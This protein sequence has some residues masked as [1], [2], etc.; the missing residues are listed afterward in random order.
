VA[1]PFARTLTDDYLP[2]S[3]T[4]NDYPD[5]IPAG[6]SVE[7]IAVGAVLFTYNW[8]KTAGDRYQRI[9]R[10]VE[11]FFPKIDELRKPPHH[12]KWRELDLDAG[13]PDWTR[14]EAAQN[15]LNSQGVAGG[16]LRQTSATGGGGVRS[17]APA[18]V[19]PAQRARLYQEFLQ[20]RQRR[21]G[22]AAGPPTVAGDGRRR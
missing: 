22:Q 19:G 21:Q 17:D 3:L 4:H 16:Q 6:Q 9:E 12:P 7:T 20:W 1:I 8:P 18:N 5:L 11:A 14:A 2:T 13:L 10:F 15:W